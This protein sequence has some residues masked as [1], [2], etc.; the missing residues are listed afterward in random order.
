MASCR[1]CAAKFRCDPLSLLHRFVSFLVTSL[2]PCL[3]WHS[4]GRGKGCNRSQADTQMGYELSSQYSPSAV[5]TAACRRAAG[6]GS[7]SPRLV[8]RSLETCPEAKRSPSHRPVGLQKS[9]LLSV[10]LGACFE[11]LSD[12]FVCF[13]LKRALAWNWRNYM[14]N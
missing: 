5:D 7:L 13:S 9:G 3:T 8:C 14:M 4:G 10:K 11:W 12:R 2:L 1:F 6:Y